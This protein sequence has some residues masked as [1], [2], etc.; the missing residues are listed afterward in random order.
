MKIGIA[1]HVSNE[2]HMVEALTNPNKSEYAL[3]YGYDFK[4][5]RSTELDDP[6]M[7]WHHLT[8]ERYRAY[9]QCLIEGQYDWLFCCGADVLFTNFNISIES[10]CDPSFGFVITTDA[11]GLN[12]D[13]F[14]ARNVPRTL[15]LLQRIVDDRH[16]YVHAPV[17]DQNALN[18]LIPLYSDIVKIVPQRELQ[19]YLYETVFGYGPQYL[20]A[21]DLYG[22]DG[23]WKPGDFALHVPGIAR[24]H[25]AQILSEM[26]K[27]VVK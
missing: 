14:I 4:L 25:K 3:K 5:L 15:E 26:L 17:L 13:V 2:M 23:Q 6:R 9:R 19:S 22:N 24:E 12:S 16:K 8:F 11:G 18:D 27:Q 21:K 10:K 20:K 7:G 1:T